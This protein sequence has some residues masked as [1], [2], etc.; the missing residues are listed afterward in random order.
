VSKKIGLLFGS[1]NPIHMGHL[2]IANHLAE[3]TDLEEVWLVVTPHNPLKE[4]QSLLA[5][6]HRLEMV[7]LATESYPKLKPCDVEF[8]LPQPNYAV[9]TLTRLQE[10]YPLFQFVLIVGEDVLKTFHLWK[11]YETILRHYPLY[12]YP[13]VGT[14]EIPPAYRR[15]P[16]I[17]YN[18][19]PVIGISSTQIREAIRLNK[20]VRPLLPPEVWR[21]IDEMNLY[22]KQL[23]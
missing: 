18:T 12:L 13:R 22:R 17:Q 4:K 14:G 15:H 6:P 11:E 3:Y 20:N 5:A 19:A 23:E 10:I 16:H 21:Y 9:H 7:R 2:I 8:S 1:F